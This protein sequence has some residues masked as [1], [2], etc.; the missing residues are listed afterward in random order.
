MNNS[1]Y[2]VSHSRDY[3]KGKSVEFAGEWT[4]GVRYFNDEY[5]NSLVVY[6]E[7]DTTGN[8]IHSALLACKKTHIAAYNSSIPDSTNNQ[9]HLIIND[10]L[11]T[12]GIEPNDYW[13]FVSGSL[14]G[15]PGTPG[16]STEVVNTYLEAVALANEHNI[17]KIVF[18]KEEKGIYII[19]DIG[20]LKKIISTS[21]LL[22]LAENKVDKEL[23]KGLSTNDFSNTEKAKLKGIEDNAQRNIIEE[24]DLNG[25]KI[26]PID[27][28][29]SINTV[30]SI[31]EQ[32]GDITLRD[33]SETAWDV[34]LH[35][36]DHE[37]QGKVVTP[38][39]VGSE[40]T[41][42]YF[43]E[44]GEIT[45]INIDDEVTKNSNK[46]VTSGAIY[47]SLD[48]KQ[49]Q[50]IPGDNITIQ[51]NVISAKSELNLDKYAKIKD[52]EEK[53]STKQDTLT[54]DNGI[55]IEENRISVTAITESEEQPTTS[56]WIN[57]EENTEVV[58]SYN[59]SQID[60]LVDSKQ[61]ILTAGKG[62]QIVG[63]TISSTV[64]SNPF[65]TV[66][67][68]PSVGENGKIYLVPAE[69]PGN[70]NVADE[71]I[72]NNGSWERLGSASVDLSNCPK[73]MDLTAII[74]NETDH[75][76][77]ERFNELKGLLSSPNT[78][79]SFNRGGVYYYSTSVDLSKIS[80][81][82]SGTNYESIDNIVIY[83]PKKQDTD[84]V[85]GYKV[86]LSSGF[87]NA[88]S[89]FWWSIY[90][91]QN[92]FS[93]NT[94]NGVAAGLVPSNPDRFTKKYLNVNGS[95]TI[96][97][98]SEL[99][100]D[101]RFISESALSRVAKTGEY[102]DLINKP[103]VKSSEE[104]VNEEPLW[105]NPDEDPEEVEVYN[106][107]QVDALLNTKQNTLVPGSGIIIDGNVISSIGG[108]G[109]GSGGGS[110][111]LSTYAKKADVETALAGKQNVIS[112]LANIR[113]GAE[114]GKT[115][116]QS[117]TETDPVY[118]AD[119]PNLATKAELNTKQNTI[120]D[121]D[122]IRNGANKG[123]TALQPI[124]NITYAELVALRDSSSLVAGMQYRIT[125]YT[126]TTTT[127]GTKSAGHVFDIIVTADSESTLNEVARAIQHERDTYFADCDLNAWKLWYSLD[128]DTTRFV[129]ADKTNGKGVIY[130]MIDEFNNDCPYDFK[131]I[132][133]YRRWD[134]GKLL[135]SIIS[136]D[137]NGIPC[138]TFSSIGNS[139]TTSFTDYSL[140][141]SNKVYSNVIKEYIYLDNNK[142]TL[143]NICFF[144][145]ECNSNTFGIRCYRN[146]FGNYCCTNTFGKNCYANIFNTSCYSNTF[147]NSC[148][149]NSFG[150]SCSSNTFGDD[151]D[152]NSFGNSCV[153]NSFW[154]RCY[155]N[156]LGNYCSYN[157]FGN[158]CCHN[159]FRAIASVSASSSLKDFV[160][161]NHFDNGSKYNVIW[162][163]N[164]T[165][166]SVL[167]KNI[168]INKGVVGTSNSYNMINIDVLNSEQEI[169]V[170]QIDGIISIS[171]IS[172]ILN[173]LDKTIEI[174]Y[175][176]LVTL[177]D[178]A[179]L[180]PGQKYRIIDYITKTSQE[181]TKSAGHQFD[182]IVTALDE[183]TLSEEAQ[184]IQHSNDKYF[185]SSN[186][187][188]WKLW[189]CLDN[190]TNRFAWAG[191]E[192]IGEIKH[193]SYESSE[194]TIKPE[195]INGNA[196]ITPFNFE[197][198]V[199]VDG[200]NDGEAY[201]D[202]HIHHDISE[203]V[204]EWGHFTDEN[205]VNQLC[206]Y[207][208]DAGLYNE[209][210]HPDYG[211]K[212]LYRGVINV[213]GTEYD[214]WQK[215]DNWNE[216]NG[217]LNI[218]GGDDYVYA[219][220]QRIVSNPEAYR[221]IIETENIYRPGKGVIYRMID[222]WNNDVP[223][224]FKNIQF[225]RDWSV[226]A[227]DSGLTGTVY[228]YTFSIFLNGFSEDAIA[229]DE[230]V[231][232]K[233]C[234]KSDRDG[235]FGDNVIRTYQNIATCVLNDIVFVTNWSTFIIEHFSNTF[236]LV[237]HSNTFGDYCHSNIFG[238]N[239][240]NNTFGLVCHSNT[241]GN[242]CY[243]NTFG[244]DCYNNI[245]GNSCCD[246]KFA[247]T[248]SATTKYNCYWHNNFGNGCQ[249]ILFKGVETA[250]S[251][252]QVQ[253]YN[254]AQG[255][256]GTANAYLTIDGVRCR[257]YETKVAKNSSGE[258]KIYCEADLIA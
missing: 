252:S 145:R 241:F 122:V 258:L 174:N 245:F 169:N 28:T 85:Y 175:V 133:F 226:I 224:D 104:P 230:S 210:G 89:D 114:K 84:G 25:V 155:D 102:S 246:I 66:S 55:K 183:S 193:E 111:D 229:S 5:L 231:K 16:K 90:L 208:S 88:S 228:C 232:A 13:I 54:P 199:W 24:I 81:T 254:F 214:Y 154:N 128:N 160:H 112:D 11:G 116:L 136:S 221:V 165:S 196:F 35:I 140:N 61:N 72:W 69:S 65:I 30:G 73:L 201:S 3:Y 20:E 93:V 153:G 82:P 249:Y 222:E 34:N 10:D 152:S 43:N 137:N 162:N 41:P 14:T 50:L 129:W 70:N 110:I 213:D 32:T 47:R 57:P 71:W 19:T 95:W 161:Y 46:L 92:D 51:N 148:S 132:Q 206:I 124:Q 103:L 182:I 233:E 243:N 181:N 139:S 109:G 62:I 91:T 99:E 87:N 177:R 36:K 53:L 144:G 96:V 101:S 184:A 37:I 31:N 170:N 64:D 97:K 220:T 250:S 83:F 27:K 135:W 219:T 203:L 40:T 118:T 239:C 191:D 80:D 60:A 49:N 18:V 56:I 78:I 58:L 123:A 17:S 195:L 126:C 2:N 23:G 130:R 142:Q 8:I 150:I 68:L 237:C 105:I 29:I 108:S 115:A 38:K 207:K 146:T 94:Y 77:E 9:P 134:P 98:S 215:W 45:P 100:N 4:S 59:R 22:E 227:P 120:S 235:H 257:D 76:T 212:Y 168:N 244:N 225:A 147:R 256:Q 117:F 218:H 192:K 157:S 205:G 44:D 74:A 158:D 86:V 216:N 240:Y 211:D 209:E 127:S 186:L 202:D 164:T 185:D 39:S 171:N 15:T 238:D 242:N 67:E 197:S 42:V 176:D 106:R 253:N 131:N 48:L 248:S 143:N 178:N 21:D 6:T 163:S 251:S 26:D 236:G 166:S 247:S 167:L 119:K 223:Y 180:I 172:N 255:L 7:K 121:L 1:Y 159:S 194:C 189:Y 149:D 173:K 107:S 190:D 138:Y 113:E 204:Y 79:F 200:N 188:A 198:C 179:Q 156:R 217:G 75:I 151:C 33:N 12:I 141:A 187:S 125:D 63:S 234:I 52:V